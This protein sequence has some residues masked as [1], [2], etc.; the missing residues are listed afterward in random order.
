MNETKKVTGYCGEVW[1]TPPQV[2]KPASNFPILIYCATLERYAVVLK[3][4]D[5]SDIPIGLTFEV[6]NTNIKI[7]GKM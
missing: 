4:E 2:Q 5:I 1:I 7:I 3:P 6:I